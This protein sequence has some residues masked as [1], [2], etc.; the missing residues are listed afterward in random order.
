MISKLPQTQG[1]GLEVCEIRRCVHG[2][3]KV[4]YPLSTSG[5]PPANR[6][7]NVGYVSAIHW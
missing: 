4:G 5:P 1:G 2:F 3:I 7:P 6:P